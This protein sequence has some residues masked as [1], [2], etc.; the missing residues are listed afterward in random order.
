MTPEVRITTWKH[1]GRSCLK[2]QQSDFL[3]ECMQV[4]SHCLNW[5]LWFT[6][7]GLHLRM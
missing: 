2:W 7:R 6:L 1:C 4:W 3:K 5:L